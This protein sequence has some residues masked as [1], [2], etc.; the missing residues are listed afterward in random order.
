MKREPAIMTGILYIIAAPS[1]A[2]KTSLIKQLLLTTPGIEVSISHTTRSPRSGEQEG[3]DYYFVDRDCFQALQRQRV[4]LEYAQV[5]DNFYGTSRDRVRQRLHQG[6]DVILEIDWQGARQVKSLLPDSCS[7]F[8]LPPALS[9]L[10]RRL[11]ARGEDSTTIIERRMQDA[12]NE[13]S[14]YDEFDYIVIN[15]DFQ[16]ALTALQ[17]IFIA[18]RQ[19]RHIQVQ[20]RRELLQALLS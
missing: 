15:D 14:H 4:F 17:A 16:E 1:G 3:V 5:F 6:V 11:E 8:I 12:V 9:A 10:R 18:N 20:R 7:I 13:I 19:Q 2:G